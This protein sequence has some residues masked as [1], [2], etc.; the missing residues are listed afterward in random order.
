MDR[1]PNAATDVLDAT[2]AAAGGTPAPRRMTTDRLVLRRVHPDSVEF[3]RFHALFAD[4]VDAEEVFELCNWEPHGDEAETRAYLDRRG[5]QWERAECYEYVLEARDAGEYVGTACAVPGDDGDAEFGFWLRKSYW[6]RGLCGE[7]TDALVHAAFERLDAPYVLAGCLPENDRSRRAIEKFVGRY[8]G[9]YVGA[10]PT[11]PSRYENAAS[12][13]VVPHH[14]WT[15]T[16][17]QYDAG[18]RGVSTLI[19]GVEYGEV[20]F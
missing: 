9:A 14:E 16:R 20:E 13:P 10:V 7:G 17:E 1:H 6:G 12:A 2:G 4:A 5:D 11:V 18:E 3:E 15:I 19:P 8:G